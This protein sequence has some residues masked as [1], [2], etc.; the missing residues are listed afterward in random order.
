MREIKK[1]QSHKVDSGPKLD[2]DGLSVL[3]S[4]QGQKEKACPFTVIHN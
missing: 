2:A 4:Q 1:I 3:D